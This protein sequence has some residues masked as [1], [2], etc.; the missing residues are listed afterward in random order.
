MIFWLSVSKSQGGTSMF[1]GSFCLKIVKLTLHG[2]ISSRDDFIC[3]ELF[4]RLLKRLKAIWMSIFGSLSQNTEYQKPCSVLLWPQKRR[5]DIDVW[6]AQKWQK[7]ICRVFSAQIELPTFNVLSGSLSKK[8]VAD[9]QCSAVFSAWKFREPSSM[10]R[11]AVIV[12]MYN[13]SFSFPA[14]NG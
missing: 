7:I 13:L 14:Q 1:C 2:W 3:L 5:I 6:I 10:S 4:S 11:L 9:A 8:E 12:A